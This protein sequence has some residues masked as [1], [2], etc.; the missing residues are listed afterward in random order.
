MVS[1]RY[2]RQCRRCHRHRRHHRSHNDTSK[3]K[4]QSTNVPL[5]YI[6][7]R[8]T[9]FCS[10][11]LYFEWLDWVCVC[12]FNSFVVHTHTTCE[13]IGSAQA[14]HTHQAHVE[15]CLLRRTCKTIKV[16]FQWLVFLLFCNFFEI[17]SVDIVSNRFDRNTHSVYIYILVGSG[18]RVNLSV[19]AAR[20][21]HI[22]HIL[23]FSGA[24]Q[25]CDHLRSDFFLFLLLLKRKCKFVCAKQIVSLYFSL[26]PCES[27]L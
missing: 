20:P 15:H 5:L 12:V 4:V 27:E 21:K 11:P 3:C 1:N 7:K 8:S 23:I 13:M 6:R 10:I 2:R 26:Y 19:Y 25:S 9:Q 18:I 14:A 16:P 24:I 22:K 17:F